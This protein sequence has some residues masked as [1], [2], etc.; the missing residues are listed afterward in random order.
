M[1]SVLLLNADHTVLNVVPMSRA[2]NLYLAGKA[3]VIQTDVSKRVIH[4]TLGLCPPVVIALKQYK[5]IRYSTLPFAPTRRKVLQRDDYTCSYCGTKLTDNNATIDH[6]TP[7]SKN[8]GNT[9]LNLTAC[10]SRCNHEKDGRTLEQSGMKLL[11]K[12]YVPNRYEF[13]MKAREEWKDYALRT[14][15]HQR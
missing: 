5:Y 12:P 2:I 13:I 9:W 1:S 15:R 11:K 6:I 3:E 7:K 4:P 10:C 14:I 8:G